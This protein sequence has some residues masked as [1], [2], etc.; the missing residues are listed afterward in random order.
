LELRD[1]GIVKGDDLIGSGLIDLSQK[2]YRKESIDDDY[3]GGDNNN[4]DYLYKLLLENSDG[5]QTAEL[6]YS[7][8]I[9][10]LTNDN[11]K[12]NKTNFEQPHIVKKKYT[13]DPIPSYDE[14]KQNK[15]Q[16]SSNHSIISKNEKKI[17]SP[18]QTPDLGIYDDDNYSDEN[19][20]GV[21]LFWHRYLFIIIVFI[22]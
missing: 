1:S 4:N 6:M 15:T 13:L 9:K 8:V 17:N 12:G 2:K 18:L 5:E 7:L 10:N 20:E 21:I 3:D 16:S 19:V 14:L 11:K 22:I